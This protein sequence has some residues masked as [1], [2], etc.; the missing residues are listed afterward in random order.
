[1]CHLSEGEEIMWIPDWV[2]WILAH[3]KLVAAIVVAIIVTVMA[4]LYWMVTK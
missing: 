3:D 4:W 2:V 1:M